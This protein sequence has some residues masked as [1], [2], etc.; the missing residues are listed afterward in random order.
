MININY[1]TITILFATL[2][3]LI[4]LFVKLKY[5]HVKKHKVS[6]N[7]R[8]GGSLTAVDGGTLSSEQSENDVI[9]VGAGVA[10]AA[11][12]FSLAKDGR[13]VHVIERDLSEP[14]RISGELLHPGGYLKLIEL[15]LDDCVDD[16]DAQRVVGYEMYKNGKNITS[17]YPLDKFS[18]KVA[19]RAFYNGRFVQKMRQKAASLPNVRL[20]Q[21]TVI[22]LVEDDEVVKGVVYKMKNGEELTAYAPLTV[23]CDGGTSKLRRSLCSPT[24]EI[25]SHFVGL[26]LKNCRLSSPNHGHIVI[27]DP[28]LLLFYPISSVEVRCLVD[29][30]TEAGQ[31]FPSLANGDMTE[32]L[33]T[34]VAPQV[35]C[36]LHEPFVAAVDEG[37]IRTLPVRTMAATPQ[38]TPGAILIGDALNMR[39]AYTGG[40][41][42]VALSDVVILRDLLRPLHDFND[43]KTLCTYLESFY[44]LRKP[45][46]SII[47]IMAGI[48]YK[49]LR[50]SE[51]D[52][53][54]EMR[55][56][57]FDYLS[58]GGECLTVPTALL[59]GLSSR[60]LSLVSNLSAVAVY[61]FGRLLLPFPSPKRL[62][63]GL[64]LLTGASDIIVPLFQAEGLRQMFFPS[65]FPKHNK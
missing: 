1:Y 48:F 26:V 64:R 6:F 35:P 4:F 59:S 53:H 43:S 5:E 54:M 18:S 65:N 39:H 20:E 13:R 12:A 28:S 3:S 34:V 61:A 23:V 36:E 9:I 41:M 33:K 63:L 8:R 58:R 25:P 52:A 10:G 60:P 19:G 31:K 49:F 56:A 51:D 38:A 27:A 42:T 22:S 46:A 14:N 50:S 7:R 45:T 47:N 62:W 55:D 21:G 29:V 57:L 30:P 37:N 40:G 11:L 32:Y 16:I 17:T 2:I 24:V 15:G 44:T